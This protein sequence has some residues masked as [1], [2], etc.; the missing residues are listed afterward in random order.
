ME[1]VFQTPTCDICAQGRGRASIRFL[2]RHFMEA[3][4]GYGGYGGQER[5]WPSPRHSLRSTL[6]S[7][8]AGNRASHMQR[9]VSSWTRLALKFAEFRCR[10]TESTSC[11]SQPIP[12]TARD[13]LLGCTSHTRTGAKARQRRDSCGE[14]LAQYFVR[15]QEPSGAASQRVAASDPGGQRANEANE[16]NEANGA[17]AGV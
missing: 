10:V 17:R 9:T 2:W 7:A 13:Y 14:P 11:R 1:A 4:G 3:Y 15:L 8:Q 16:A 5:S 6:W 12:R